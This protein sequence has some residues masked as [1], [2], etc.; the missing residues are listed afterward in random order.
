MST[1]YVLYRA[2]YVL[3]FLG[4]L[5]VDIWNHQSQP[6]QKKIKNWYM[7]MNDNICSQ[8]FIFSNEKKINGYG[9]EIEMFRYSYYYICLTVLYF[10]VKILEFMNAIQWVPHSI[11]FRCRRRT[12]AIT[13]VS[14]SLNTYL[15]KSNV[16]ILSENPTVILY[17]CN[18]TYSF[19]GAFLFCYLL[20]SFH[21]NLYN[22]SFVNKCNQNPTIKIH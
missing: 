15:C 14:L 19:F 21:L 18:R 22:L 5:T 12:G 9:L 1:Q 3:L 17:I 8:R 20:A 4:M 11:P 2:W 6:P 10:W 16:L 13:L 7:Y